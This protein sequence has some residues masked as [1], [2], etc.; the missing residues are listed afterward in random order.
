MKTAAWLFVFLFLVQ[1]SVAQDMKV[2]TYN[3][4][5]DVASDGPDRWDLRKQ[6]MVKV[7]ERENPVL[8]GLQEAI[9]HQLAYLDSS[10][11]NHRAVG[12]GR[13]DG[14]NG[15]E[16]S[17]ILYDTTVLTLIQQGTFWLSDT[18]AEVSVGWDAALPRICTWG[19]FER[20]ADGER[21]WCF[22]THF[23]HLGAQARLHSAELILE[24]IHQMSPTDEP[25]ILMGDLNSTPETDVV[26]CLSKAM[27][28]AFAIADIPFSGTEG[29]FNGFSLDQAVSNRID[30]VFVKDF[31][32]KQL[33]HLDERT[34]IG[35][36]V[37]D[38]F[39][40]EAILA[41]PH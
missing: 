14:K 25:V 30:Y 9:V 4:R 40:V 29:T 10:L 37:S 39:A 15:G 2:I 31:L 22:N 16:F 26:A 7:L 19:Q 20:K 35:R 17:A 41:F 38:H 21:F 34:A 1:L 13:D 33:N 36:H 6:D 24:N 27:R 5:L 8:I 3:I 11:S 28:D 12:V 32:V 18:P 23:D